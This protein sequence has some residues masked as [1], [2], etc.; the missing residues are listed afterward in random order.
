M[1]ITQNCGKHEDFNDPHKCV[2]LVALLWW[3][4]SLHPKTARGRKCKVIKIKCIKMRK[5]IIL[6]SYHCNSS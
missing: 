1:K 4:V 6:F 5:V 3:M 2:R